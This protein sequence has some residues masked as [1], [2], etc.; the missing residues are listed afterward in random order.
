MP[1]SSWP[2]R[3]TDL[4]SSLIATAS[5]IVSSRES[6]KGSRSS[7][8]PSPSR[9]SAKSLT[10]SPSTSRSAGESQACCRSRACSTEGAWDSTS[11]DTA[12]LKR[13]WSYPASL[14]LTPAPPRRAESRASAGGNPGRPSDGALVRSRLLGHPWLGW[15]V[16]PNGPLRLVMGGGPGQQAL[17]RRYVDLAIDL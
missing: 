6:C 10:P 13:S 3:S 16:L 4:M 9:S 2:T 17:G 12:G 11:S 15:P 7:G 5:A 14:R 8:T 1:P